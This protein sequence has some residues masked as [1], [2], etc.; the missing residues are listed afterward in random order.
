MKKGFLSSGGTKKNA[1]KDKPET[2]AAETARPLKP[3]TKQQI[4]PKCHLS[5]R[6]SML[7]HASSESRLEAQAC[8]EPGEKGRGVFLNSN[9]RASSITP[10]A[11]VLRSECYATVVSD[12]LSSTMCSRCFATQANSR[13]IGCK[14]FFCSD[15]CLQEAGAEHAAE[16]YALSCLLRMNLSTDDETVR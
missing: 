6:I 12:A 5:E 14:S 13:C 7:I 4:S 11:V 8:D 3:E 9:N 15:Q 16:C 2:P 1:T 10:G